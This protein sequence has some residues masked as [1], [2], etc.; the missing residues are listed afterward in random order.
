[1]KNSA[2]V[3]IIILSC[4]F[5][6]EIYSQRLDKFSYEN[7]EAGYKI[8]YAKVVTY[9]G[10]IEP[11]SKPDEIINGKNLYYLYFRISDTIPEIGV[12]MISPVPYVVMPDRGDLVSDNYF[13]NEKDK[14]N[15]FDPWIAIERALNFNTETFSKNDSAYKWV[16]LGFND[17]SSELFPQPN[18]KFYNALLRIKNKTSLPSL[19]LIPGLYRIAFTNDKKNEVRGG[20]VVQLG[21]TNFIPALTLVKNSIELIK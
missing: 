4:F 21:S 5:T 20:F 2:A 8:T 9:F 18:G 1:M 11:G 7:P 6:S 14:T 16:Q 12:R 15:Y 13:D 10:Y 3:F 17:D 19:F